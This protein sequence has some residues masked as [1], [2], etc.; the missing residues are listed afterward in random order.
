[1]QKIVVI[2]AGWSGLACAY[3]LAKAGHQVTVLEAAPQSGGRART[4]QFK[5]YKVDN[6]QHVCLGAYR[7]T[8][9]L[10]KELG[11][12]ERDVFHRMPMEIHVLAAPRLSWADKLAAL[13]F[14][15]RLRRIKFQLEQDCSVKDLLQRFKQTQR[16]IKNL[17]EPL[18]LA[19][20]TTPIDSGSAQVFINTLRAAFNLNKRASDWLL[21]KLDLS[22]LLPQHI[23]NFLRQNSGEIFFTTAVK[24]LQINDGQCDLVCSRD[25]NWQADHVV[26]AVPPW[27]AQT[28]VDLPGL[29]QF[30][31]QPIINIYIECA[32]PINLPYPIMGMTDS[33]CHWIFDRAFCGQANVLCAVISGPGAHQEHDNETLVSL[34]LSEI[35][36]V[37]PKPLQVKDTLV[38][39]EKRAAFTCD[40]KIQAQRPAAHTNIRNVWLTGDYLQNGLPATLESAVMSGVGTGEQLVSYIASL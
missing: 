13:L 3:T 27:Q 29:D 9:K 16:L 30:T 38:I 20:M 18:A 4:V 12:E 6:G 40:V 5:D 34:I 11:I 36:S 39:R 37:L 33:I 19:A 2:G 31:Y 10:L 17:W 35:N 25:Q 21:P 32:T 14:Y 26:L 8:L 1:M 7:H 15:W 22:Q 23:E 24:N 28:L